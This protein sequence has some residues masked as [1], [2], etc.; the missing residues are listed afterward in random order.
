MEKDATEVDRGIIRVINLFETSRLSPNIRHVT[1]V[2]TFSMKG[3]VVRLERY[4]GDVWQ[5]N[6]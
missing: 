5:I 3:Q 1:V 2:S 4:C 6:N